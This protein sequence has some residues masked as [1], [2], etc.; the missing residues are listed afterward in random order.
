MTARLLEGIKV[1]DMGHVVAGPTAGSILADWGAEVVKVE[2]LEGEWIRNYRA[3]ME[4]DPDLT[5][6]NGGR[7]NWLIELLNRG[8]KGIAVDL[9]SERGR[10]V[11][12]R[13]VAAADVFLS[14]HQY[15]VLEKL[16]LGWEALCAVNPRLVYGVLSGFGPKGPDRDKRGFDQ[17]LWGR[18]GLS[19]SITEPGGNLVIMRPAMLDRIAGDQLVMGILAALLWR[20][21]S[22]RGQRLDVSLFHAGL[23]TL[24][25]DVQPAMLG[26][27]GRRFDRRESNNP[28]ANV[29]R[30][31]DDRWLMLAMQ[32]S[33]KDWPRFCAAIERPDLE[34]D[35]RFA[36]AQARADHC[37]ELIGILDQVFAKRDLGTWQERL[38]AHDCI[39]Q[40]VQTY[41]E[42]V[43]DPQVLANDFFT[44]APH[45]AAGSLTYLAAPVTFS[46]TPGEVSRPAPAVGEHSREILLAAGFSAEAADALF[47]DGVVRQSS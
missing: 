15:R 47:A 3:H 12:H 39:F 14:N 40:G 32:Q 21:R 9:K 27:H 31:R 44:T 2:P 7:V 19:H 36:Q 37:S 46:G 29:Y 35:P 38:H 23:W 24:A 17:L 11:V 4:P 20:E 6:E 16:G 13:L 28:L 8:K 25:L 30:T 33:Q 22:G 18:S 41:A 5:T 42:V 10:T 26:A 43:E 1:I 34:H 45:P